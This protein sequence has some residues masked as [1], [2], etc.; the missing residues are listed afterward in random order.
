MSRLTVLHHPG[1][2]FKDDRCWWS[3]KHGDIWGYLS[4]GDHSADGTIDG[5]LWAFATEEPSAL[6]DD[7]IALR[8]PFV[9]ADVIKPGE[10]RCAI[11]FFPEPQAE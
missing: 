11:G 5:H 7:I 4:I 8:H 3:E 1:R 2:V 6:F 10:T 9:R